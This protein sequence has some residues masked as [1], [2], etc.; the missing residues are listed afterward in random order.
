[1]DLFRFGTSEKY[2]KF[3]VTGLIHAPFVALSH[4]LR[5]PW[6]RQ[7]PVE[8]DQPSFLTPALTEA[9]V[10]QSEWGH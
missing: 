2:F 3:T 6:K 5:L 10:S 7:T 9:S 8:S 4:E 1:M